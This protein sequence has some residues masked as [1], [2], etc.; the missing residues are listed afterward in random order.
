MYF[1][2]LLFQSQR[3]SSIIVLCLLIYIANCSSGACQGIHAGRRIFELPKYWSAKGFIPPR[4]ERFLAAGIADRRC[5]PCAFWCSPAALV[6][7]SGAMHDLA[8]AVRELLHPLLTR[9]FAVPASR[10]QSATA[11]PERCLSKAPPACSFMIFK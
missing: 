1:T 10:L 7:F 9:S 6:P 11:S 4:M 3:I 2:F 5:L 8:Q